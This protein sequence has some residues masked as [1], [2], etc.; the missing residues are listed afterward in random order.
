[1]T[2]ASLP[3]YYKMKAADEKGEI[4]TEFNLYNDQ[5][6]QTLNQIVEFF[7]N[8]VPAPNFKT[9]EISALE[10]EAG[11]GTIWFNTDLA[12]LQ[13]KTAAGTVETI[14]SA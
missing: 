2:V 3:P 4:S 6:W 8:G 13:V 9:S 5:L 7:N 10:P 11:I 14:T 12:K 1:M